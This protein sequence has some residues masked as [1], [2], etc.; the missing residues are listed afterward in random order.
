[1]RQLENEANCLGLYHSNIVSTIKVIPPCN[2]V[3]GI[4]IMERVVGYSL[5]MLLDYDFLR[6]RKEQRVR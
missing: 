1:M 5:E 4:V 2:D 3:A 6:N